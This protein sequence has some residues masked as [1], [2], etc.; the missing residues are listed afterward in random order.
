MKTNT[1]VGILI[2]VAFFFA[3]FSYYAYQ[4]CFTP[5]LQVGMGPKM[6][7]I[8]TGSKYMDVANTLKDGNYLVDKLSFS[9]MAKL[10]GYQDKVKPG[11]YLIPE[12]S[13][14]LQVVRM[15][16]NGQQSPVKL[17]FNNL[18][19][20]S[21]LIDMLDKKL[22]PSSE[23]IA[24]I[25][26]NP[27]SVSKFGFDTTT[28]VCM[29][30]PNT[31]EMFWN[32]SARG[33]VKRMDKEYKRFWNDERLAKAKTLGLS[34][35]QVTVLASI[36]EAETKKADEMP[37][38]AGV[39]LNRL[40]KGMELQADPT[41]VFAVGDFTIKRV[42]AGHKQKD[43]PY[44]TYMYHGLPPGPINL[45][46]IT[47]IDAALSPEKHNYLYFCAREDFSGYHNFSDDFQKH[48]QNARIYQKA[49]DAAGY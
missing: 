6:L 23:Q 8:P 39:Y 45:P 16:K 13:T 25:L 9:F 42:R 35:V 41:V 44:N 32:V 10:M 7:Y 27:D 4:I 37:R 30:I 24:A 49:L 11:A 1:K 15:L 12:N 2:V 26:N 33:L 28:I 20:K 34:P 43:S 38:V 14:N 5:N 48:L 19:L 46:S 36:T 31:Y 29:F 21:D 22:E 3:S 40:N 18:R 17:T 47:A